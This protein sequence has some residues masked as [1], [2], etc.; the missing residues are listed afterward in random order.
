MVPKV[1]HHFSVAAPPDIS[2][3]RSS[4][5]RS[6]RKGDLFRVPPAGRCAE[7]KPT[8][9]QHC[10]LLHYNNNALTANIFHSMVVESFFFSNPTAPPA[11]AC[12][13]RL[14]SIL[15]VPTS[16]KDAAAAGSL[17][18]GILTFIFFTLRF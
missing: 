4:S 18:Y 14:G 13:N 5:C 15:Q 1:L 2:P 16:C 7:G 9:E 6:L 17:I 8:A 3:F 12:D 10:W 11:L